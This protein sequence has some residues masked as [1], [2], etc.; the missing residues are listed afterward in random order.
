MLRGSMCEMKRRKLPAFCAHGP[1]SRAC[2]VRSARV[3]PLLPTLLRR[4]ARS[5]PVVNGRTERRKIE[6]AGSRHR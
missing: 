1:Q 5:G 4:A 2:F 3:V 6:G